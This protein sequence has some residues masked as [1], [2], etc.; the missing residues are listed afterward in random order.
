MINA[1][2]IL[3]HLLEWLKEDPELAGYSI[4]RGEPVNE[5]PSL[6]ERGWIGLYRRGLDYGP[7]NLGVPPNNYEGDFRFAIV[8]QRTNLKS[9]ADAEDDLEQSV[10]LV[11]SRAVQVP[12]TY[13][14]TFTDL[15]V[16]YTYIEASTATMYFQ[17]A[18]I[19]LV[20]RVSESVT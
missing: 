18:L 2:T 17:G 16:D 3:Q 20:A 5:N 8:V 6:A 15:T 19:N 4:S 11:L 10:I 1:A 12:R 7:R 9:G 13:I 14:D